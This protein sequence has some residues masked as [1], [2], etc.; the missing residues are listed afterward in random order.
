MNF[1][2]RYVKVTTILNAHFDTSPTSSG[3]MPSSHRAFSS[4]VD[5]EI[6]FLIICQVAIS[7]VDR[8]LLSYFLAGH[9]HHLICITKSI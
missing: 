8:V 4:A 7:K 2:W 9:I 3:Q 5:C 1:H 6:Q